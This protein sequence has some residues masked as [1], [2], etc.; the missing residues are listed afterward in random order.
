MRERENLLRAIRKYWGITLG[1]A[2]LML[3]DI[4][5]RQSR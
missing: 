3:R 1:Q 2:E 4:E 5:E